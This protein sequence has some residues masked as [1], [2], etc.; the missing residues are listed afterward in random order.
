[1]CYNYSDEQR[2]D[3]IRLLLEVQ[4]HLPWKKARCEC[5]HINTAILGIYEILDI[6][7]YQTNQSLQKVQ[8]EDNH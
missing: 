2:N 6:V 3:T 8:H 1:M 7:H 5:E 4:T